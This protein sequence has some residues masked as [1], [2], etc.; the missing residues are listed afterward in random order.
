MNNVISTG[1]TEP[2]LKIREN[3]KVWMSIRVSLESTG[4]GKA[5]ASKRI[6]S[7]VMWTPSMSPRSVLATSTGM[8]R[9]ERAK[10]V[11]EVIIFRRC[12][13]GKRVWSTE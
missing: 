12:M 2:K 4:L 1:M 7:S 11:A 9:E 6:I 10:S 3:A 5:G 8:A 13:A